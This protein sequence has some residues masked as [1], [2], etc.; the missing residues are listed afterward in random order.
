MGMTRVRAFAAGFAILAGAAMSFQATAEPLVERYKREGVR[1]GLAG[2]SPYGYR[3]ENGEFT[4][5]NVE[6][7]RHVLGEMGVDKIEFVVMDFGSLIPALTAGRIDMAGSGIYI[8]PERCEAVL[9]AEPTTGQ[10]AAYL[11]KAGNPKGLHNL[12]DIANTEGAKLA[13]LAGGA[14]EALALKDGVPED[15]LLK[16][17]DKTAGI[18]ALM[19]GRVDGFALTALAIADIAATAGELIGVESSGSITEIAGEVYKGHSAIAFRKGE[20][21]EL[22]ENKAFIELFNGYQKAY[23]EDPEGYA[24]MT[25]RWGYTAADRPEKTTKEL[26]AAGL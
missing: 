11:V 14:E 10:G 23:L 13:V 22:E 25:A 19:S 15:K 12:K 4:G 16:V 3:Q 24:A 20:G 9:F 2:Y 1:M 7:V 26:C 5:E 8:R 17:S 18:G 6:V 21:E